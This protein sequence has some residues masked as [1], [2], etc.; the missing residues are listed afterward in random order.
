VAAEIALTAWRARVLRVAAERRAGMKAKFNIADTSWL[1]SLVTLSIYPDGPARAAELLRDKGIIFVVEP[2]LPR[3][4]LDGAA[5]ML[6]ESIPVIGLT[7]RHDRLDN[8][9]FTLLHETGHIFLHF[10]H[11]LD[12]GF[13][14]NMDDTSVEG[15][16]IEADSFAQS[17]LLPDEVWSLSPA[18]FSKSAQ[19]IENFAKARNIHP[20][21][22][23]GR[24]RRD[25]NNYRL[26]DDMVGRGQVRRLFLNSMT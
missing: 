6:M 16:E 14:D 8:F 5:L 19:L 26:F 9:W 22:V 13:L 17:H 7:L 1:K 15:P 12:V 21:I 2:H 3:T 10:N 11:G 20:A 24:I 18:R 25:R 4:L 23:A